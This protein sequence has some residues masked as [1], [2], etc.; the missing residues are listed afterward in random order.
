[1]SFIFRYFKSYKRI[2]VLTLF[3]AATNQI[4]SLLD[5]QV[6]RLIIDNYVTNY[7]TYDTRSFVI[8]V[9]GLLLLSVAVAMISRIAKNFQDYFANVMTQNIGMQIY[10]TSITHAFSLPYSV[11]EDQQSGQLLDK[12]NKARQSIQLFITSLINNVF[13]AIVGLVF[14][15]IYA[16]T[17]H[18]L[19]TIF[20]ASVL[21]IMGTII[22]VLSKRL[23]KAQEA[24]VTETAGLA[25]ATTET[26]RNVGLVKSLGLEA[27]EMKRLEEVNTQILWLEI[28]KIKT[29]R[30]IDFSQWTLINLMR[31]CLLGTMFWLVY[32]ES[33]SLGQFFSLYFYSFYIF[34]PLYMLGEV[35]K[36]YQEAKASHEILEELLQQKPEIQ[37]DAIM[38]PIDHID[39]VVFTHVGFQYSVGK[40]VLHDIN[41]E[42]NRGETIAFV[43]PSGSGKSTIIK[44]LLGL[45]PTTSWSIR[46]N[47]N[48]ISTYDPALLKSLIGLVS[49]DT[50]LFSGTIRQNLQFVQP[51]AS[52]EEMS[53]ALEYAQLQDLLLQPDGLNLKIGEWG[54]KLSGGQKQRLAIARALL[55]EP[56]L[57]IFDEATSSLDSIVE[58]DITDTI[59]D[60]SGKNKSL[61]TIL[62]A[63]RLSTVV[64]ADLIYVL[65]KGHII[66][67]G[68]HDQLVEMKGLYY[69]LR[70][71]QIG[72]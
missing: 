42:V 64:H 31:V 53:R 15:L 45:Y 37:E 4:F 13:V 27:Q 3:L 59:K 8:G 55:R 25:G 61:S 65:E 6:F 38:A 17:V 39:S 70:R 9:W 35:L 26:I 7:K 44:L 14:V 10:Q 50:Q 68:T 21:P 46:I 19:I 51:E 18:W 24:I 43:W 2:L 69:S 33:I 71:Q 29:V 5:P 30:L 1:M 60:I 56:Q 23:K 36:N 72:E 16:S 52:D 34:S 22:Y 67:Q 62:I 11:L 12:L 58:A 48:D 57:L 40:E 63:H 66:E 41:V 54:L 32:T 49:Q 28:K 47:G 20:Y